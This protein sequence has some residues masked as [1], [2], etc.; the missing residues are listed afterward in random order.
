M[1]LAIFR[2]LGTLPHCLFL[3]ELLK[4]MRTRAQVIDLQFPIISDDRAAVGFSGKKWL[5]EATRL[6]TEKICS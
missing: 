2:W 3:H 4:I 5:I 6:Q 1:S